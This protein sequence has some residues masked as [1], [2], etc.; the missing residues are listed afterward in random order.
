MKP[1]YNPPP[2]D[3]PSLPDVPS[4]QEAYRALEFRCQDLE[5]QLSDR[6]FALDNAREE[7]RV[8]RSTDFEQMG[9]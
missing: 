9:R 8:R 2:R 4:L 6:G 5:R 7:I 3:D 1:W